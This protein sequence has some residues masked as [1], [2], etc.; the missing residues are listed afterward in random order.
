MLKFPEEDEG[1]KCNVPLDI[2]EIWDSITLFRSLVSINNI[3][4]ITVSRGGYPGLFVFHEYPFP[5]SKIGKIV[6]MCPPIHTENAQWLDPQNQW[7]KDYLRTKVPS[8]MILAQQG[9]YAGLQDRIMMIGGQL[10][11]TCPPSSQSDKFAKIV[12]CQSIVVPGY[13]HNVGQSS[14]ARSKAMEFVGK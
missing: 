6:C 2:A 3:H 11:T 10:D 1:G 8:P 5:F 13:G 9:L 4:I 7:A 12:G 14:M